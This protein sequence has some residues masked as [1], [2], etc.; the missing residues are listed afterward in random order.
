LQETG[1]SGGTLTVRGSGFI[2][3]SL[4]RFNGQNVKTEFVDQFLLQAAVP[5]ELLKSGTFPVTVENP[6]FGTVQILGLA[7]SGQE[8]PFD[9][10]SNTVRIV[11]SLGK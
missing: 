6:N 2:P 7:R 9:H 1:G 10:V 4:V 8:A 3:Y 11:V 5:A